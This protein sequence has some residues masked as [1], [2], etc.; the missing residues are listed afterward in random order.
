MIQLAPTDVERVDAARPTLQQTVGETAGRSADVEADP[1]GR[2]D[3]EVV[4]GV[5]QL[6]ATARD[7]PPPRPADAA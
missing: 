7:K 2:I 5:L 4:E 3:R 1:A 6:V